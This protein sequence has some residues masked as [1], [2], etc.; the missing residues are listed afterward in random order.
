MGIRFR[1]RV[2]IAPG[3]NMNITKSGSSVTVGGKG[4]SINIG[5]N[6]VYGNAGI[7]GTGIYNRQKI[8][9]NSQKQKSEPEKLTGSSFVFASL[10]ASILIG[11]FFSWALGNITLTFFFAPILFMVVYLAQNN[12]SK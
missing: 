4:G 8:S 10:I 7:P 6:G 1:K 11:L 5:K 3:V 2:K 12:K 9:D